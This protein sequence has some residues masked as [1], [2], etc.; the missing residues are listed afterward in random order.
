MPIRKFRKPVTYHV[1][2]KGLATLIGISPDSSWGELAVGRTPGYAVQDYL[3]RKVGKVRALEVARSL[4]DSEEFEKYFTE[5][6]PSAET[7]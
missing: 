7:L 1:N 2:V 6:M 3:V 5:V 4:D